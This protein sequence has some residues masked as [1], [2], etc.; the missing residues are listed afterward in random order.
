MRSL[1][2]SKLEIT[3]KKFG[4]RVLAEGNVAIIISITFSAAMLWIVYSKF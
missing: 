3:T 1:L 4:L 2:M